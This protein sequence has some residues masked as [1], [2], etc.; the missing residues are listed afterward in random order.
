M[1]ISSTEGI[2]GALVIVHW[3]V[4]LSRQAAK[5]LLDVAPSLEEAFM[6]LTRDAV[7]YHGSTDTTG[8]TA[9]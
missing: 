2:V 3:G 9:A 6:E 7:D 4:R 5:Q 8:R 1:P